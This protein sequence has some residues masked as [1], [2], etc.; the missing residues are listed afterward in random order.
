MTSGSYVIPTGF[1]V[2]AYLAASWG[3]EVGGEAVTVRLKFKPDVAKIMEETIWHPSQRVEGQADGSI[4]MTLG[5]ATCT[6]LC[7]WILGWGDKVEVL[8]PEELRQEIKRTAMAML[9]VY[10]NEN[11]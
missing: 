10:K 8:E 6:E 9:D 1:D 11:S 7:S 2:N 4:I 5:V 3:I